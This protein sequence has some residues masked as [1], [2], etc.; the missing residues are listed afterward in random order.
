MLKVAI[1]IAESGPQNQKL[2]HN[3]GVSDPVVALLNNRYGDEDLND[4][5]LKYVYFL[6]KNST[7]APKLGQTSELIDV[8]IKMLKKAG[9]MKNK[10]EPLA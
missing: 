8:M 7:I 3:H 2:L 4:Q 6:T 9:K 1:D 5:C 10:N